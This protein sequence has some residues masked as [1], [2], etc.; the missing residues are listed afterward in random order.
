[1]TRAG[2]DDVV[3][4]TGF[5]AFAARKMC[6]ELLRGPERIFVHALVRMERLDEAK[7]VL[8]V[9]PLEQRQRVAFIV[10]DTSAIDFGLAREELRALTKEVDV[11]HHLA[12]VVRP[13]TNATTA[14]AVNVHG[15]RE[16]TEI[17]ALCPGLKC[18]VFHSLATVSGDRSGPVLETELD[19]GQGFRS[20]VEETL[21]H[22]ERVLRQKATKLPIAIVRPTMICGDT[23]T[24]DVEQFDGPFFLLQ[25]VLGAPPELPLPLPGRPETP[26]HLVPID[27]VMKAA[28]A[29][30]RD[31]R[32]PGRTFHIGDPS[33]H[34]LRRVLERIAAAGGRRGPHAFLPVNL[35]KA[36][37]RTPGIDRLA[38]SPRSFLA[39]LATPVTYSLAN[40]TEILAETNIRCPP[41]ESYVDGLVDHVQRSRAPIGPASP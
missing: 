38:R 18:L 6:E 27:Y 2:F 1:M 4:L 20:E 13:G 31:P 8:D 7:E 40:T 15:A 30:G 25:L 23:Q 21:A 29:I 22:A 12:Q 34:T 37:L 26:L 16:V 24:G 32:S 11:I 3:L 19:E 39:T 41:F 33:P 28:H 5:P 17:A 14:Y 36:L 10:G 35:T 9:L